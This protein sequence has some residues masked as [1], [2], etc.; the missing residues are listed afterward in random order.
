METKE[1]C[2][3]RQFWENFYY[4]LHR[5]NL[6]LSHVYIPPKP[7]GDDWILLC[8]AQG[9]TPEE[10]FNSWTFPKEDNRITSIL[11]ICVRHDKRSSVKTY[12][13]WAKNG[14]KPD[15]ETYGQKANYADPD[16][17]IGM[18]LLERM[19]LQSYACLKGIELDKGSATLCSGS[20]RDHEGGTISVFMSGP[21]VN[22]T[23]HGPNGKTN[24]RGI[25]KVVL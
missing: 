14:E 25:R 8:V 19:V 16:M 21:K 6:K 11:N 22:I 5:M 1:I 7:E 23:F 10:V 18:N 15:T 20:K 3:Y 2:D 12:F 4:F 9:L 24:N 17:E 13:F